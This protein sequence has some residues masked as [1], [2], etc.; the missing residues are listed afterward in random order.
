MV[1]PKY[2]LIKQIDTKS[3]IRYLRLMYVRKFFFIIVTVFYFLYFS[4]FTLKYQNLFI[5]NFNAG[6]FF[7][8]SRSNFWKVLRLLCAGGHAFLPIYLC[9]RCLVWDLNHFEMFYRYPFFS[10][11]IIR[12]N[13]KSPGWWQTSPWKD[14]VKNPLKVLL[15]LKSCWIVAFIGQFFIWHWASTVDIG[16]L[17]FLESFLRIKFRAKRNEFILLYFFKIK[18]K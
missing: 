12:L 1:K 15:Q 3:G 17:F 7:S 18:L 4:I 16:A 5:Y 6:N 8:G 14:I 10:S 2:R 13:W 9:K 11:S